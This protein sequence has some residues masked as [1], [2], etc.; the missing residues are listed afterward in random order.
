MIA[1]Q[2][3]ARSD[4]KIWPEPDLAGFA[5]KGLMINLPE[6]KSGASLHSVNQSVN[7]PTNQ[8]VNEHKT[9]YR[10]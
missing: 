8:P 9:T 6:P 4:Q 5:K 7:Q 10:R 3:S 2:N 1:T